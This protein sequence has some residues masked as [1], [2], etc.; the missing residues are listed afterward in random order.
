MK[1]NINKYEGNYA[2][3][4][5]TEEEA[6]IF[7]RYLDSVGRR[8]ADGTSY[9]SMTNWNYGPDTCY[10][11]NSGTYC[12]KTYFLTR[13]YYTILEF[14]DFEW[15]TKNAPEFA[16]YYMYCASY[17]YPSI[18][19]RI[20]ASTFTVVAKAPHSDF[21]DRMLYLVQDEFARCFLLGEEGLKKCD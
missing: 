18:R 15:V 6:K 10:T 5:K 4:C 16:V 11:F 14:S 13:N 19:E 20:T 17:F 1:F 2:M 8:W 21:A 9:M 3:H 12:K 7:C